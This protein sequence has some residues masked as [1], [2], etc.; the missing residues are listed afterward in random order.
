[1]PDCSL[2]TCPERNKV[3]LKLR[4]SWSPCQILQR[5]ACGLCTDPITV[6]R[7]AIPCLICMVPACMK[8][9]A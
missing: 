8:G 3:Y 7:D 2:T 5:A 6:E 1:M 4:I 9:F